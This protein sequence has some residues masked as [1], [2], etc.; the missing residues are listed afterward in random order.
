MSADM[1]NE[2][3]GR[4]RARRGAPV[5]EPELTEEER[6]EAE[7]A[8][9]ARLNSGDWDSVKPGKAQDFGKSFRRM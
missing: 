7:L 6:M 5:V 3:R 9:Q 1:K 4:G 8:E 2:G